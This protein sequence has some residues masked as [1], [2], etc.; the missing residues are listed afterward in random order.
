V[1]NIYRLSHGRGVYRKWAGPD[2]RRGAVLFSFD[3]QTVSAGHACL[4]LV[5]CILSR[6]T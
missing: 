1:L 5:R 3:G 4:V 2:R 6:D